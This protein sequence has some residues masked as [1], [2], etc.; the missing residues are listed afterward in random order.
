MRMQAEKMRIAEAQQKKKQ[1]GIQR[2]IESIS[3]RENREN[4]NRPHKY[5]VIFRLRDY[6]VSRKGK[7]RNLDLRSSDPDYQMEA[8]WRMMIH[9]YFRLKKP[10]DI[11]FLSFVISNAS[12]SYSALIKKSSSGGVGVDGNAF[13]NLRNDWKKKFEENIRKSLAKRIEKLKTL[14][15]GSPEEKVR[16]LAH[17]E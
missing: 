1:R 2:G 7:F 8:S 5:E 3:K 13:M 6:V 16:H 12:R 9:P 11:F 15:P 17:K 10:K 14:H 4:R